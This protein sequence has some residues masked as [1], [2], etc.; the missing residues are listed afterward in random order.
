MVQI[1]WPG[2]NLILKLIDTLSQGAGTLTR[3]W[4]IR[5]EA[6]ANADAQRM[7]RIAEEQVRSDIQKIRAGQ[8]TIGEKYQLISEDPTCSNNGPTKADVADE[9]LEIL[10]QQRGISPSTLLDIEHQ[11]N[12]EQISRIAL[13]EAAEDEQKEPDENPIDPD[14][15]SQWRSRAQ[16]VSNEDMQRLWAK[17]LVGEAK[18]SHS[19]SIHTID[20][21][22][23]ISKHEAEKISL[24]KQFLVNDTHLMKVNNNL[25]VAVSKSGITFT[26]FLNFETMG[27]VSGASSGIGGIVY[28]PAGFSFE[29]K[30]AFALRFGDKGIL[31]FP[32]DKSTSECSLPTIALTF[33]GVEVLR[34]AKSGLNKSYMN[35]VVDSLRDKYDVSIG[36]VTKLDSNDA[37]NLNNIKSY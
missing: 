34:L 30:Q 35:E 14:W 25:P 3:P 23:R 12:L 33:M 32:K 6:I 21:L 16:H 28:K 36:D 26:D 27:L 7:L 31:L 2:E 24:L 19:F 15:F 13:E 18:Q 4:Q 9:Y 20:F 37:Y 8:L 22:A 10:R 11:I 17:I 29:G 1:N 5:R